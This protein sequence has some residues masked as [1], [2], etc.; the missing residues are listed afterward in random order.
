[1][2]RPITETAGP[3]ELVGAETVTAFDVHALLGAL[4][5]SARWPDPSVAGG[6]DLLLR[7]AESLPLTTE[8]FAF[9]R[10]WI[11]GARQLWEQG[12]PGAARYQVEIVRR[13]LAL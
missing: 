2:I 4:G 9:A 6:F 10:C 11:T 13:R 7:V 1:M 8:E 12:E 5:D 3:P